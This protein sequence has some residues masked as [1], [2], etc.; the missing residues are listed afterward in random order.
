LLKNAPLLILDEVTANLDPLTERAVL[1]VLMRAETTLMITHRLIA[2]EH[3]DEILVL[4]SGQVR[5]RGTHAQLLE[6]HGL[7]QQL[8]DVQNGMLN[9]A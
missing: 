7:Y 4:D 2:M 5:E 1:D 3:M 8:F 6:T 9:L